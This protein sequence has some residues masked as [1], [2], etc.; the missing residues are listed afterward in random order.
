[1]LTTG[2]GAHMPPSEGGQRRGR[3]KD[4]VVTPL[5]DHTAHSKDA[6]SQVTNPVLQLLAWPAHRG[7]A[8]IHTPSGGR[9]RQGTFRKRWVSSRSD[10][11]DC[12]LGCPVPG[13]PSLGC[14]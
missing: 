9:D 8:D 13:F 7:T 12:V 14:F 2:E 5:P 10:R 11:K 4:T 3:S 6:I 1:M